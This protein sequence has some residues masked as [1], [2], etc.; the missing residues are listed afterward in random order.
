MTSLLCY[1][2]KL[3]HRTH[4]TT[5]QSV[6]VTISPQS[7]FS[8]NVLYS[9]VNTQTQH[10]LFESWR[11][12]LELLPNWFKQNKRSIW[13]R[14][15]TKTQRALGGSILTWFLA[16]HTGGVRKFSLEG[17][18]SQFLRFF[19]LLFFFLL[20]LSLSCL[21]WCLPNCSIHLCAGFATY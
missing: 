19:F 7:H 5:V 1:R 14:V 12:L 2:A 20:L 18:P 15:S 9:Q 17:N 16:S 6:H 21:R 13:T 11:Q 3:L 4:Q 10:P 8:T